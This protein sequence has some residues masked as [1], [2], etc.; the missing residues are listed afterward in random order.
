MAFATRPCEDLIFPFQRSLN[1]VNIC[2][3]IPFVLF[4][5]FL[6][7]GKKHFFRIKSF[8]AESFTKNN[9]NIYFY[10]LFY[11]V[12]IETG[13]L[14][15][16][17]KMEQN[18]RYALLSVFLD[19]GEAMLASG[20]EIGRVEDSLSRMGISYGAVRTD[21]FAITSSLVLTLR[22]PEG[23]YTGSRRIE[24][25]DTNFDKLR[26]LNALSRKCTEDPISPKEMDT[27]L[28]KIC[29]EKCSPIK[30][31]LGSAL[32][33]GA[34]AVFFGGNLFD[35]FFSALFGL[36]ICFSQSKITPLFPN[37]AFF[38]FFTSFLSGTLIC[39]AARCFPFLP[40][41]VDMIMIG[42]IMLLIPGIATTMSV[43]DILV[44]DTISGFTKLLECVL[45][46]ASLAAGFV[47]AIMLC[48]R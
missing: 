18:N 11:F 39:L 41:H 34:F 43:R 7:R 29:K 40:L 31:Y 35:G 46:A 19:F 45:W 3:E 33:A 26:K 6:F 10:F 1:N 30:V 44:G 27:E 42:D 36:F 47:L 16:G 2:K 22:F 4:F 8:F 20:A 5:S 14:Y 15:F 12:I 24:K 17:E 38:L 48:G 9:K 37:K 28:K 25:N 13:F 21:V 32:A 23:E